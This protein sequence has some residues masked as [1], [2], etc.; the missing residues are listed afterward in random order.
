MEIVLY[1]KS[2]INRNLEYFGT[3]NCTCKAFL[4]LFSIDEEIFIT[5]LKIL[6][7]FILKKKMKPDL[8]LKKQ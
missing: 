6:L 5:K 2:F 1:T 8:T 4:L 3:W 7:V